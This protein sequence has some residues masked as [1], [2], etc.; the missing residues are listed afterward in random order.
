MRFLPLALLL[1]VVLMVFTPGIFL[2][3]TQGT[4]NI[5]WVWTLGQQGDDSQ[6]PGSDNA[7]SDNPQ[8]PGSDNAPSDNP[9]VLD[10]DNAP[11]DNPQLLDNNDGQGDAPQVPGISGWGI[12]VTAIILSILIPLALRKRSAIVNRQDGDARTKEHIRIEESK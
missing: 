9:Q 2:Q 6:P 5:G 7:Q 12:I 3:Q 1:A 10:N 11:S 4:P 8:L